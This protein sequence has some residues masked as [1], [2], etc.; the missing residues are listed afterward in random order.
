MACEHV[1]EDPGY[2]HDPRVG[3]REECEH[4]HEERGEVGLRE[5]EQLEEEQRRGGVARG[6]GER[7]DENCLDGVLRMGRWDDG[8]DGV[9]GLWADGI[10]G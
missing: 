4:E 1:R 6:G 9:M 8:V 10:M 5:A 7:D 3:E 2:R